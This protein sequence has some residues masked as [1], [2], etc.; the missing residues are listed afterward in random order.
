LGEHYFIKA[1]GVSLRCQRPGFA[2]CGSEALGTFAKL[3]YLEELRLDYV[4]ASAEGFGRLRGARRLKSLYINCPPNLFEGEPS[5]LVEIGK[6][7]K[8][9]RLE[10]VNP[11]FDPGGLAPLEQLPRLKELAIAGALLSAE[12]INTLKSLRQLSRLDLSDVSMGESLDGLRSALPNCK[13]T[14]DS[15]SSLTAGWSN[16]YSPAHWRGW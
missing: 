8:L 2:V 13:V 14:I 5:A 16:P 3:P 15:P 9:Q 4:H 7:S 12:D 11:D 10:L 1:I 6:L